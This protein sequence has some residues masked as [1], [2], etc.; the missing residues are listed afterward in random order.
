MQECI[1]PS[2]GRYS[3]RHM[4]QIT[5]HGCKIVVDRQ[6]IPVPGPRSH[7]YKYMIPVFQEYPGKIASNKAGG[8]GY[9]NTR[10]QAA[11]GHILHFP[12][13]SFPIIRVHGRYYPTS[14][15]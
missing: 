5:F 15:R 13:S 12:S 1:R 10:S 3:V 11:L 8:S 14:S 4:V 6:R 2:D 9:H 7:Q